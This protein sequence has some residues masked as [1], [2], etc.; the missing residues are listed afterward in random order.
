[1]SIKVLTIINPTSG[2]GNILENATEIKKNLE[3]QDM[4]VDI[5][6]TKKDYNA[7]AI[8]ENYNQEKDLIL[9]CGG[10]GTLNEVVTAL[11]EKKEEVSLSFIPFGTT[12]D[13]AKTLEIPIKD[14]GITKNLLK[15]KARLI[16]IGKFNDKYF[17]YIAAFGVITDVAYTTS[18]EA[19]NKYGRLAYYQKA[20][21][22]LFHKPTYK[23]K[24]KYSGKLI[25]DEFIYGGISNSESIAGFKW[26]E[27]GEIQLD[28]GKF[29]AIFIRKPKNILGYFKILGSFLKKEY[30]DNEYI[31]FAQSNN[32]EIEFQQEINWTVDGE[33]A[34]KH[35]EIQI[36]NCQ[37]AIELA[38]CENEE[39]NKKQNKKRR[40]E[41]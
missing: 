10:D 17:C 39:E 21:K 9:V 24:I 7:K 23:L 30:N 26:F 27:K 29:E 31:L 13:L 12:N 19:K 1:M 3:E 18:R 14:I 22:E 35:K 34:G 4:E 2:K 36:Q 33:N 38:I 20:I 28:D 37:K 25:E 15:S 16:D 40:K 41:K 32:F 6:I 5:Q 11:I 8:I